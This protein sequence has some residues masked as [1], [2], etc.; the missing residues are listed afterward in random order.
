MI[1]AEI[2]LVLLAVFLLGF[3]TIAMWHDVE[4]LVTVNAA[5]MICIPLLGVTTFS[6]FGYASN[7]GNIFFAAGT[8]GIS[9]KYL[10]G[11]S[12]AAYKSI[13]GIMLASVLVLGSI[14][15]LQ[16]ARILSPLFDTPIQIA[17]VRLFEL[18]LVQPT[19]VYLLDRPSNVPLILRVPL[20]SISMQ[21][22]DCLVFF[23]AAFLGVLPPEI[24]LRFAIVGLV[25]RLA[26]TSMTVPFFAVAIGIARRGGRKTA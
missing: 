2:Y 7:A 8:Y 1:P 4:S 17:C 21:A 19:F 13:V 23:P 11:G 15:I 10:L 20:I 22:L 16:D 5:V 14:L 3:T 26:V 9:L 24:M 6:A 18:A 12:R 25:T